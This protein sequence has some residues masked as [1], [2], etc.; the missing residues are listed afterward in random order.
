MITYVSTT[1]LYWKSLTLSNIMFTL[2]DLGI[3]VWCNYILKYHVYFLLYWD[4]LYWCA[5]MFK[6]WSVR[7][8]YPYASCEDAH[9][10]PPHPFQNVSIMKNLMSNNWD[11]WWWSLV[12]SIIALWRVWVLCCHVHSFVIDNIFQCDS[13]RASLCQKNNRCRFF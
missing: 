4:V 8:S 7:Q 3:R 2:L 6:C 11:I 1:L 10:P 9:V 5:T 13:K 12:L